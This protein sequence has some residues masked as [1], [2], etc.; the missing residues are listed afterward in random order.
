MTTELTTPITVL[1]V[2]CETTGLGQDDEAISVGL[3]LCAVDRQSGR[4][5]EAPKLYQGLRKPNVPIHPAAQ[6]VHGIQLHALEGLDFEH[7]TVR[8]LIGR[9][10]VI[11]AHNAAFDARMLAKLYPEITSKP[12][13]CS[14]RQWPWTSKTE[15]RKL[16]DAILLCGVT[17][18]SSHQALADAQS[19]W[20]CLQTPT[21]KT[22]RSRVYLHK[23]LSTA[24]FQL[25]YYIAQAKQKGTA[26]ALRRTGAMANAFMSGFR[27]FFA[28]LSPILRWVLIVIAL[29]AL[30]RCAK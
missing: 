2:D 8:N 13:R 6:K 11:I 20:A 21:G 5:L 7:D 19:L 10:D 27:P 4:A 12:W 28:D 17:A 1:T 15:G 23:L 16:N 9:A 29:I 22:T 18:T 30:S 26:A 14:W 25:D 3:V 24:P